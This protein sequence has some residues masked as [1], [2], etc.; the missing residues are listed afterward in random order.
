MKLSNPV[1]R[2]PKIGPVYLKR[3]EKLGIAKI[4]DLLTHPPSRYLDYRKTKPIAKLRIGD[5]ASVKAKLN[6]IRN[7]YT[8]SGK[9]MQLAEIEDTSG[10]MKIIWF[11]QPYLMMSLK[12]KI[13]Y[14]FAGKIEFFGSDKAFIAPDY[15][16]GA[17]SIHTG[18]LIPIYPETY[19][20]SSKWL[21]TKIAFALQVSKPE[22][23]DFIPVTDLQKY[24]LMDYEA[25]IHKL[26]FPENEDEYLNA[27]KR[28]AF[29]ELLTLTIRSTYRKERWKENIA[30]YKIK[31]NS[32]QI[33]TFI[34]NLPFMLTLSQ[35][36]SVKEI[37][38]DLT[39]ETPMNR[40]LEGDVGS[41]KTVVAAI[42]IFA[43][44]LAGYQSIVMAPTQ[45]LA[46]QHFETL[47]KLFE[48]YK[49]R[50]KL[51]TSNTKKGD[52]GKTDVFVGTHA[53]IHR[54]IDSEQVGII[55]IDEQHRFGVEQRTHLIKQSGSGNKIPH[56][57]TMTATPIP[58]TVALT[59]YGDLDLSLLTELPVG[60]KPVTTWIV[61]SK[62]RSPAYDW[63]KKQIKNEHIQVFNICPLIEESEAETLKSV[64]AVVAEFESLKKIFKGYRVDI[65][66]GRMKPAEK[67][68]AIKRFKEG[69][70]DILVSTPVVE[71][72]IDIANATIM[73]VEAAERFGLAQLHQLRGRV[74]RNDAQAYCLLFTSL[75][76]KTDITRLKYMENTTDGPKLAELDLKIRG[77]GDIFGKFQHGRNFLKVANF[78][79]LNLI[80]IAK[81]EAEK[82][83]QN[84]QNLDK[85]PILKERLKLSTISDIVPN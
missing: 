29:N 27:K 81:K 3:L 28:L 65:L 67:D 1:S 74:G 25:A 66:H 37:L 64:R 82:I 30:L 12:R 21:R 43:T 9:V 71:V 6:F 58:R 61:P 38:T 55:V 31:V 47:N 14:W 51:I 75:E 54:I 48:K 20:V 80:N 60:R 18:R 4:S 46:N 68:L 83:L 42:G 52:L 59:I 26:H 7:Q 73:I 34:K 11:N 72:G 10:K 53:L 84:D 57:L 16:L 33:D 78:S 79:D 22:I 63:I 13:E 44:F 69:K 24:S 40:L 49:I 62:K 23:V 19:G 17:G 76:A 2:L 5:I 35:E 77:P 45:I 41:G 50:V 56:V 70:S 39:K 85:F 32:S 8:K 36:K 15:E